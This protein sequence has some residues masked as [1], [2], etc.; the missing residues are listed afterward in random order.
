MLEACSAGA[1]TGALSVDPINPTNPEKLHPLDPK[2]RGFLEFGASLASFFPWR[3]SLLGAL[4]CP[5][6]FHAQAFRVLGL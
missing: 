5:W 1:S 4:L 3:R 6:G 2:T